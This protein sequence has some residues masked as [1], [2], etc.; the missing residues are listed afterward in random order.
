MFVGLSKWKVLEMLIAHSTFSCASACGG[1]KVRETLRYKSYDLCDEDWQSFDSEEAS[2]NVSELDSAS[3]H[4]IPGA[5]LP[6][7]VKPATIG[8]EMSACT[9]WSGRGDWRGRVS[10]GQQI[11]LGDPLRSFLLKVSGKQGVQGSHNL[12]SLRQWKSERLILVMKQGNAC[13]AK[14]L[15]HHRVFMAGRRAA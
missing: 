14:G 13:G 4:K 6:E 3:L 1:N 9:R 2:P 8:E 7:L 5:N 11:L 10:K 12:N 15:Y